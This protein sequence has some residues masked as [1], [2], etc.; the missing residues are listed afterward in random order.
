MSCAFTFV[1]KLF[2][3]ENFESYF[4]ASAEFESTTDKINDFVPNH[5]TYLDRPRM[6]SSSDYIL[7]FFF[8]LSFSEVQNSKHQWDDLDLLNNKPL[9]VYYVHIQSKSDDP[10]L[11]C[12]RAGSYSIW[13]HRS[14]KA[15]CRKPNSV[16]IHCNIY[17][18]SGS[19]IL[20][21]WAVTDTWFWFSHC[22]S[23]DIQCERTK[24]K[25]RQK[26]TALPC[27]SNLWC[28]WRDQ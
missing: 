20:I 1:S 10:L 22:M 25:A 18:A 15:T 19:P 11:R 16:Q 13:L 9:E 27:Q 7:C 23:R 2:I 14:V 26:Q 21:F 8:L 24:S 12:W 6:L 4:L 5:R 3:I 28:L 17:D